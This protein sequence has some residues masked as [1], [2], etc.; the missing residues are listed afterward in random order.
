MATTDHTSKLHAPITRD[1]LTRLRNALDGLTP[2]QLEDYLI[3]NGG[4]QTDRIYEIVKSL[5]TGIALNS[6]EGM[7]LEDGSNCKISGAYGPV[8]GKR[9]SF[10]WTIKIDN[11][12][13]AVRA[14]IRNPNTGKTFEGK[15]PFSVHKNQKYL[16]ITDCVRGPKFGKW[17]PVLQRSSP[18]QSL[19]HN[20]PKRSKMP[21]SPTDISLE[22]IDPRNHPLICGLRNDHNEIFAEGSYN[23]AKHNK[24]VPYRVGEYPAPVNHGDIG[25]FLIRGSWHVCE[26]F[27]EWWHM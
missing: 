3:E 20:Q 14:L 25:E 4:F 9:T 8:N 24:F 16:T 22:H 15:I 23:Y 17:T 6:I 7:D 18:G 13:G 27:R 21:C 10:G 26:F 1:L 2:E 12:V 11:C 5:E 19:P